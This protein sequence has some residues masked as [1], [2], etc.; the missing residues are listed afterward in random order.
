MIASLIETCELVGVEPH[1]YLTDVS[2]RIV[3]G[4]STASSR[5][6]AAMALP[7]TPALF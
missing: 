2:T 6:P 7:A 3:E 5:R 4:P 1:S